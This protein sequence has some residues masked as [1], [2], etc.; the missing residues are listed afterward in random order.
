MPCS[1]KTRYRSHVRIEYHQATHLYQLAT[2]FV[3]SGDTDHTFIVDSYFNFLASLTSHQT[4][5]KHCEGHRCVSAVVV[6]TAQATVRENSVGKSIW[7][8]AFVQQLRNALTQAF[9]FYRGICA[10][11]PLPQKNRSARCHHQKG[12][13]RVGNRSEAWFYISGKKLIEGVVAAWRWYEASLQKA[14]LVQNESICAA[15]SAVSKYAPQVCACST[16]YCDN[17]DGS[18]CAP[19]V[20]YANAGWLGS[21]SASNGT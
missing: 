15:A 10:S 14:G 4:H 9:P 21:C 2:G 7:V 19:W 11:R 5:I 17:T 6:K 20:V 8:K 1:L 16:T 18:A 13:S 12:R 3:I